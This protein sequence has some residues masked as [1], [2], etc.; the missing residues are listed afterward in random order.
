MNHMYVFLKYLQ[1]FGYVQVFQSLLEYGP[2]QIYQ[3]MFLCCFLKKIA[4][5]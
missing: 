1:R 4:T 5:H 3:N 2:H